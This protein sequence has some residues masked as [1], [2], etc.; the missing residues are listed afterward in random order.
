M[1]FVKLL[2]HDTSY[3]AITYC[4]RVHGCLGTNE[5]SILYVN[6]SDGFG[7]LIYLSSLGIRL[8]RTGRLIHKILSNG[9][10]LIVLR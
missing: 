3:L 5:G 6:W 7:M 9:E 2:M 10:L 4:K 8:L 1:V